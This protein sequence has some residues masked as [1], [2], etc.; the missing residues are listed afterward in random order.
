M[1]GREDTYMK[2]NTH[3]ACSNEKVTETRSTQK[4]FQSRY[5]EIVSDHY[6]T[7]RN[8]TSCLRNFD[9]VS[10]SSSRTPRSCLSWTSTSFHTLQ[11]N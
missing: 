8:I 11:E 10:R 1:E 2:L 3:F 7:L 5:D 4:E 9:S 6:T